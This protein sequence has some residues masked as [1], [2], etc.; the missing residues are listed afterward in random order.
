MSAHRPGFRC[1]RR[2]PCKRTASGSSRHTSL[3]LPAR[4][5][6]ARAHVCGRFPVSL[7]CLCVLRLRP[8]DA[9]TTGEPARSQSWPS[10]T[11]SP[12]SQ[13]S[14]KCPK[15]TGCG[16]HKILTLGCTPLPPMTP[17]PSVWV[18]LGGCCGCHSGPE[19]L[20]S[21]LWPGR[22]PQRPG[23]STAPFT[24]GSGA[25]SRDSRGLERRGRLCGWLRRGRA[26]GGH[27]EL[28]LECPPA[29]AGN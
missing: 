6:P 13:A 10:P 24:R 29:G 23:S 14:I 12:V 18:L 19:P 2:A 28:Y 3:A 26:C 21:A 4:G 16:R 15:Y 11:V 27:V 9:H 5:V 1:A 25:K 8:R 22:R 7:T 17:Q 20:T